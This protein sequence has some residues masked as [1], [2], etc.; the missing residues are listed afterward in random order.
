MGLDYQTILNWRFDDVEQTYTEK[1]SILYALGLGLGNN[2][3]DPEQIKY[4]YEKQLQSFPTMAV[5]LGYPGAWLANPKTGIDMVKVLHGEQH[6]EIH[7]D[8]PSHGTVVGQTKVLDIL[9][10]GAG[11]GALIFTQ[12]QLYDKASGD[13]L[14]TQK[15]VVFARSNG[16]FERP[17]QTAPAAPPSIP[18]R[19]ADSHQDIQ[20]APNAALLYRLSGDYNP[21]HADPKIAAKAGFQSPI[22]HGLATF[23]IAARAVLD[24]CATHSGSRLTRFNV[25]FSAPVYPGETLRTEIWRSGEDMIFRC[26]VVE[27]DQTVLNNGA[28]RIAR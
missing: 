5:T 1:D 12:R 19:T 7:R 11:K 2:P 24:A 15:A 17:P 28:A 4:L 27:R 3:T 23:G 9:D 22:L 8:L 18:E 6:L 26:K 16:G 25:R 14:N 13:L 21:L 20:I 10:K